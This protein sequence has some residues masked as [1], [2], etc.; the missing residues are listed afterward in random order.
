[1][2]LFVCSYYIIVITI[3]NI[4]IIEIIIE[5]I[6]KNKYAKCLFHIIRALVQFCYI[7]FLQLLLVWTIIY[8]VV[9]IK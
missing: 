1:M 5:V 3:I 6:L 8:E 4:I 7:L 2:C 9:V